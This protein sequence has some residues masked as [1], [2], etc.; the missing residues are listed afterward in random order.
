[1]HPRDAARYA[2]SRS[3]WRGVGTGLR[4]PAG[5]AGFQRAFRS[6]SIAGAVGA[7]AAMRWMQRVRLETHRPLGMGEGLG[8][9]MAGAAC[10]VVL[11]RLA[12]LVWRRIIGQH[13]P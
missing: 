10:A 3:F 13:G 8:V 9:A 7:A 11:V 1:M 5:R 6:A 4:S 12:E 2:R